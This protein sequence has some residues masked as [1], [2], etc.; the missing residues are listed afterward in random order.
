[1][2][3]HHMSDELNLAELE[4]RLYPEGRRLL[5]PEGYDAFCATMQELI[6]EYGADRIMPMMNELSALNT[7][8]GTVTAVSGRHDPGGVK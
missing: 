6:A 1:M 2:R 8:S 5:T 3:E 7:M 4:R